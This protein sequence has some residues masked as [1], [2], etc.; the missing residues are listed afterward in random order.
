MQFSNDNFADVG[1]TLGLLFAQSFLG[2]TKEAA[3][4]NP[5]VSPQNEQMFRAQMNR[6]VDPGP[7][8]KAPMPRP[9]QAAGTRQSMFSP[10][11]EAMFRAQMNRPVD[12]GPKQV[13]T[14][15]ISAFGSETDSA[16]AA[17]QGQRAGGPASSSTPAQP[18]ARR[19]PANFTP[20]PAQPR[21]MS[22][23]TPADLAPR[24]S[25]TVG[26]MSSMPPAD[27]ANPAFGQSKSPGMAPRN[28]TPSASAGMSQFFGGGAK[29]PKPAAATPAA[30]MSSSPTKSYIRG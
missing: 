10:Q 21:G 2:L 28:F 8:Q 29:P 26:G 9:S 20:N 19:P 23:A 25:K 6:P 24:P 11:N 22:R 3:G 18:K 30:N 16:L 27:G 13:T 17:Q 15:R 1:H 4:P 12:P 14:R 7:Q 5:M